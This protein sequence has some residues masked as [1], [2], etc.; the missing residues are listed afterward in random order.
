M[1]NYKKSLMSLAAT[2]ALSS[3]AVSANYITLN[4]A[5]ANTPN[6]PWVLFGVTGLK[7]NGA[8]SGS[9]AGVFSITDNTANKKTDSGSDELFTEGFFAGT[10]ESLAKIKAIAVPTVEVRVDTTSLTFNNTEPVHTMYVTME[11]GDSPSFAITYRAS[12]EGQKMQYSIL[13]DGSSAHEITLSSSGTYS[14]PGVG[15]LI[16]TVPGLESGT[17]NKIAD[18]VDYDLSNNPT[19]ASYYDKTDNQQVAAASEYIRLYNYDTA[20]TRW[21]LYDSRNS[22][23][24]NDFL[25][26]TKGKGYWGQ[27]NLELS[28]RQA[29]LV[30]GSS[31]ISADEYTAAG[32]TEGWNLLAFS[33][34]TSTI[35]KASTGLKV[36]L[37]G[38]ATIQ[39]WD[40]SGN[41]MVEA[42]F[43]GATLA[44]TRSGCLAINQ[45]IK[46]AKIAGDFPETFDL[47]AF[48]SIAGSI[49]L[50][51]NQR[52]VIAEKTGT[53]AIN[54]VTTLANQVPYNVDVSDLTQTTSVAVTDLGTGVGAKTAVMSKYGEYAMVIEPLT[55]AGVVAAA[56]ATPNK[57]KIHFQNAADDATDATP[58]ETSGALGDVVTQVEAIATG[59]STYKAVVIDTNYDSASAVDKVLV[60]STKPFFIRDHT[61][62]RV[63]DYTDVNANSKVR[64]TGAGADLETDVN[65]A[66]DLGTFAGALDTAVN[67]VNVSF[68]GTTTDSTGKIVMFTSVADASKFDV[69]ENIET[70]PYTDQLADGTTTDNLAKGAVKGVWSLDSL[71][72]GTMNNVITHQVVAAEFPDNAADKITLVLRNSYGADYTHPEYTVSGIPADDA[73]WAAELKTL[74][75]SALTA[76]NLSAVVTSV[77]DGT[78][79][80]ITITSTEVADIAWSWEAGNGATD[81]EA[82]TFAGATP[83]DNI[84]SGLLVVPTADLVEDLKFNAV[85]TPNYVSFGPLYTIMDAGYAL[86]A[87]VTGTTNISSGAVEWESIDLTRKPSEWLDSQDYSL[88]KTK[89]TSGYWAYLEAAT[90]ETLSITTASFNPTYTTHFNANGT[91]YNNVAGQIYLEVAGL[92]QFGDSNYDNSSV[93]K[94][95]VNGNAI[96]LSSK[97]TNN[98]YS[99]DLSSYEVANLTAGSKYPVYANIA[100]GLG[101]NLLNADTGL[102]VDLIKPAAPTVSIGDGVSVAFSSTSTDVAGYYVFD[103]KVPDYNTLSGSNLKATLSVT[104]AAAYPLCSKLDRLTTS[105]EDAYALNVFAVDGSGTLGTGNAS[106]VTTKNYI[107]ILKSAVKVSDAANTDSEPTTYGTVYGDDCVATGPQVI[108]Y[109]LSIT[110]ETDLQTVAIAYEPENGADLASPIDVFVRGAVSLARITYSDVYEGSVVYIKID[111]VVYSYTLPT[112]ANA[113]PFT[114]ANPAVLTDT[115]VAT[116]RSDQNF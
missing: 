104:D 85:F 8:G 21:N 72:T 101:S 4:N 81:E 84:E 32:I 83:V 12:M 79:V 112:A 73:A 2:L 86:K 62:T 56:N 95:L 115:A 82:V 10:G 53:T 92:P 93:I 1:M 67:N 99:G 30:L 43:V 46:D 19:T 34:E 36:T 40:S 18:V 59:G 114:S 17:L 96:E 57:V 58:I 31:S 65:G 66:Q 48:S 7:A 49:V 69:T 9:T 23:A 37:T 44:N 24:T 98:V 39:I 89:E 91:T 90:E 100:N 22:E 11:A 60:A 15:A 27:M 50:M 105:S 87:L 29:G 107:P 55:E 97:S 5:N 16:E 71:A 52:F 47:K 26:L 88:F 74:I 75:E 6:A 70:L 42:A 35:R 106:D 94:A 54:A 25:T 14:N 38:A 113:V 111:E 110:S 45:A 103:G 13:P 108:D 61:F 41:H 51:S 102:I 76:A 77:G 116:K 63:F 64:V 109:G 3:T 33:D 28:D 68:V 78:D 80:D 20:N